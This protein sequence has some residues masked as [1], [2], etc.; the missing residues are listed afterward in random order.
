MPCRALLH[1]TSCRMKADAFPELPVPLGCFTTDVQTADRKADPPST[2]LLPFP[3]TGSQDISMKT[4]QE[5]LPARAAGMLA[6]VVPPQQP[7]GFDQN[8]L[9]GLAEHPKEQLHVL[10]KETSVQHGHPECEVSSGSQR[11]LS[12]FG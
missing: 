9:S 3:P 8:N 2:Q 11:C 1:L 6:D 5:L 12:G 10:Q 7:P 4:G